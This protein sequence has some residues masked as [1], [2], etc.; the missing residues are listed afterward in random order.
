MPFAPDR[1]RYRPGRRLKPG[2]TRARAPSRIFALSLLL[3]TSDNSREPG[4]ERRS[5]HH[6]R[7]VVFA[8]RRRAPQQEDEGDRGKRKD[9][10]Q[11]EV[12]D[13]ADDGSLRLDEL[14]ERRAAARGPW[15]HGLPHDA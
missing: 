7:M 2:P 5:F 12:I 4:T 11:F 10:H 15:T 3:L 6:H 13:V 9:H 8:G 14:I 1:C